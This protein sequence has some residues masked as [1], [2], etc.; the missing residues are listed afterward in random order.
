MNEP[1]RKQRTYPFLKIHA[2]KGELSLT[3][4]NEDGFQ[5]GGEKTEK[6]W[7][8]SEGLIVIMRL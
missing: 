7:N 3:G 5:C 8:L 6:D 4:S 1:Q 2:T